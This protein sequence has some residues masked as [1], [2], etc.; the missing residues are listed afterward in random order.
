[1][2]FRIDF[3][4]SG[5]GVERGGLSTGWGLSDHGAIGCLVAVDGMEDVVDSRDAVDW[6][7]VQMTVED[8]G[9]DR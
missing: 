4:L 8:K 3:A 9:E 7:K 2:T 5:G 6:L 1:M